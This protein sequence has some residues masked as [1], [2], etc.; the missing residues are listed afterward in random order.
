MP[1]NNSF[2]S[3]SRRPS[4][5]GGNSRGRS[6]G[7]GGKR[8][9][10]KEYINPSRF[11]QAAKPID[12]AEYV[13]THAFRDF[14]VNEIIQH[15]LEANG[16]KIPTPIQDE[17]IP[18]G[19]QGRDVI[20]TASTGTGKT[21]A[22]AIPV[23]DRLIQNP[24]DKA[25][26]MAPTRE[27][28]QQI[29]DDFKVIGK[30][31]GLYGALLIGGTAMGPQLGDLRMKPRIV[32]GTPG[33][34]KDH[35][36]RGTLDLH[37]FNMIVLDEVDRMLDMGFIND[38]RGILSE[39]S[40]ERQSFFYSATM[41]PKVTALINSFVHEPI[42]VSVKSTQTSE[43]V[44]QNV[45]HY[46]SKEDKMD[47][48]HDLLLDEKVS[49]VL[50]FDETQRSVERLSNDLNERGFDTDAIHGGK[51]QS[52]R[53]R[54]LNRF[55]RSDIKVLVATDVAARGIDVADISH[56]INY[57]TPQTYLDYI[58]RVGRAG[59]AGRKGHALTFIGR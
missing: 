54:A 17:S 30:N 3:R 29:Q 6:F 20:G 23:L 40:D 51:S 43:N 28:A 36:N 32:I 42:T 4:F 49:K 11:I 8:K 47:K 2:S 48:L 13:P 35:M 34:I 38:I 9:N 10:T 22:F 25:L 58:H 24:N 21:I 12:A 46:D 52:Q 27:L 18:Y 1:Y 5:G 45:I 19:L 59:R 26:I 37:T 55:K 33:R 39:L 14:A 15:N 41:D 50:V 57:T 16:F 7:G 31:S 56:V 53:Q 44:E